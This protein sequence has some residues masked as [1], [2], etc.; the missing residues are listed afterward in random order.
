MSRKNRN[1]DRHYLDSARW[2][3][4][5]AAR[6]VVALRDEVLER[7]PNNPTLTRIFEGE[8]RNLYDQL[9]RHY[10]DQG[11]GE[12]QASRLAASELSSD[13]IPALDPTAFTTM[14]LGRLAHLAESVRQAELF[15]VT[16]TMYD[17]LC[18]ATSALER[19]HLR[20]M[21][22]EDLPSRA[23]LLLFPRIQHYLL[24]PTSP[25]P[26]ELIALSWL[27]DPT[28]STVAT[29]DGGIKVVTSLSCSA[30]ID[31]NG[32]LESR[33][34]TLLLDMAE[35]SGHPYPAITPVANSRMLLGL[36]EEAEV[37][38]FR[39]VDDWKVHLPASDAIPQGE[40][41]EGDILGDKPLT[42]WAL[43]FLMSFCRMARQPKTV[44]E[45][46]FVRGVPSYQAERPAAH[47]DV[48][49][50]SLASYETNGEVKEGDPAAEKSRGYSVRFPVQVHA[51]RQW[52][53]S[54]GVHRVIFRGPFIK[55]PKDAPLLDRSKR[56]R[57]L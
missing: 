18:A 12:V 52:Y 37:D 56:V 35:K 49:V 8:F 6:R 16:P 26:E 1:S 45:E 2:S 41:R 13:T 54:D 40:Y 9:H 48:R 46:T 24:T 23:G 14:A 11:Y 28:P 53:P 25:A 55:G 38:V 36:G 42:D 30:W 31:V 50:V 32:P 33:E 39:D 4:S 34:F 57:K 29:K 51:V 15:I 43:Q 7:L 22:L 19:G 3:A 27:H 47:H 20:Y 21:A 10:M 17:T 5:Q 44:R